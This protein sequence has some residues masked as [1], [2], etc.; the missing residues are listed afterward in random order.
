MKFINNIKLAVKLPVIMIAL[1]VMT[2]TIA[3][4]VSYKRASDSL[5]VEAEK[6]LETV[7]EARAMELESWLDGIDIDIRSQA[8]N[9]TVLS[10]I[11]G[12]DEAWRAIDGNVTEHLQ[13]WYIDENPNPMGQKHNLE[14]AED[15]SPYSQVHK[16]YHSYFRKLVEEKGYYDVFVFDTTGD[17]IYSVFK[18]RDFATNF[19][20]G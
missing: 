10:A 1:S 7:T 17:L 6:M 11:R 9:P 14:F 20:E 16:L 3:T 18:E 2:I 15:G 4:Y 19:V 5:L 12:F 13:T 8:S